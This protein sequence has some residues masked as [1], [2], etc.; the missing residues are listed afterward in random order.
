MICTDDITTAT[1]GLTLTHRQET[2]L[3]A[4]ED[5]GPA[6]SVEALA[7]L[8]PSL[9]PSHPETKAAFGLFAGLCGVL[10]GPVW[11]DNMADEDFADAFWNGFIRRN[12]HIATG[13]WQD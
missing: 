11:Q 5:T 6:I 10:G 9:P 8:L 4:L 13:K 12:R 7:Y 1:A 3:W 2:A